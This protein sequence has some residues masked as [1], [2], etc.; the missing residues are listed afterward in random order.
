MGLNA[1]TLSTWVFLTPPEWQEGQSEL[2]KVTCYVWVLAGELPVSQSITAS[3]N[4]LL[5]AVTQSTVTVS[6]PGGIC[7]ILSEQKSLFLANTVEENN[8]CM[9]LYNKENYIKIT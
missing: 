1:C 8:C 5:L 6:V 7:H 9:L 4:D 2:D 3:V